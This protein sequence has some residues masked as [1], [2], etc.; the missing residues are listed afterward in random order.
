MHNQLNYFS[1]SITYVTFCLV[2]ENRILEKKMIEEIDET[3]ETLK[4]LKNQQILLDQQANILRNKLKPMEDDI[5]AKE[6][7]IQEKKVIYSKIVKKKAEE[8]FK[9]YLQ[10]QSIVFENLS[11]M[12]GSKVHLKKVRF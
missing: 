12:Y 1:F 5:E 2:R 6:K 4:Q 9:S 7:I 11:K 10:A 3:S 8:A